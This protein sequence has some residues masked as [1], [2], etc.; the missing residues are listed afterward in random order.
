M[1]SAA[2]ATIRSRVARP[3]LVLGAAFRAPF[4]LTAALA[5]QMA[6]RGHGR[7]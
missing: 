7:S 1:R 4:F 5:P 2:A 6:A 3:F